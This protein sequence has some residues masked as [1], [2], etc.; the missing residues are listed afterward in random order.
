MAE[1]EV[2]DVLKE[3]AVNYIKHR[4]MMLKTLIEINDKGNSL[5]VKFKDKEQLFILK[6]CLEESLI[7]NIDTKITSIITLNSKENFNFL[8]EN[9]KKLVK[10][11]TLTL[12]FI[13]PH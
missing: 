8:I 5:I 6:P 12:F 13:N 2:V 3:W 4:D 10:F 9:W 11:Q 7:Q 1:K